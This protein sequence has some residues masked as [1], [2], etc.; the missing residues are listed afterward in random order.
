MTADEVIAALDLPTGTQVNRRVPKTLLV[1][2]GAATA[3]DKRRI[4]EGVEQIQWVAVLKPATV[5]VAAYR[6][7]VREYL[8]IAVLR[9]ILRPGA[10]A[11]RLAELLHR[12]VPYPVF[13][14][15][16]ADGVIL[17]L[18]H[19]RWSQGETGRTVLDGGRIAVSAPA[20]LEPHRDAF[21]EALALGRQPRASLYSLYQ[22]WIDTFSALE[23]ARRTGR[24]E[25]LAEVER[26]AARAEALRE[27]AR[28]DAEI[29][30]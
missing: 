29:A 6:D 18:A 27:C 12:A 4:N 10:K 26:R 25:V 24:F 22:G 17:S 7:E 30:R 28:L 2:H 5:G 3:A 9:L 8:E 16:E 15:V 14:V 1:E 23:A 20:D 11:D 21:A 19:L 13:A